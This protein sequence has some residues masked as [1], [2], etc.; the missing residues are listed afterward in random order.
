MN[1]LQPEVLSC[2]KPVCTVGKMGQILDFN[3]LSGL[4]VS[5][6]PVL[7]IATTGLT[8]KTGFPSEACG[9][10]GVLNELKQFLDA[11][12]LMI[13]HQCIDTFVTMSGA[14]RG[15]G[16]LCLCACLLCILDRGVSTDSFLPMLL[17]MWVRH[18]MTR[19]R[20]TFLWTNENKIANHKANSREIWG[21]MY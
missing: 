11:W 4:W 13:G 8:K 3:L 10:E 14:V 21:Q 9:I 6:L 15:A 2:L 1:G 17:L 19:E 16:G 5:K 18:A 20:K 7:S 12:K